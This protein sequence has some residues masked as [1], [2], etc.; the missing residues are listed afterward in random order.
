MAYCHCSTVL[1]QKHIGKLIDNLISKFTKQKSKVDENIDGY[2][3]NMI[4]VQKSSTIIGII[5]FILNNE[6]TE[7]YF[8]CNKDNKKSIV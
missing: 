1:G 3:K 7:E 5:K 2:S 6:S 4:V 8:K